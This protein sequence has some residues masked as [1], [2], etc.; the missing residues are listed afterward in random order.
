M[1]NQDIPE[2][3]YS[4]VTEIPNILQVSISKPLKL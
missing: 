3:S 4:T 1:E 2:M